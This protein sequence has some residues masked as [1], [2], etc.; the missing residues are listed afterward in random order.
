MNS[1]DN[2]TVEILLATYNG[3]KFLRNQLD[4]ILD[5]TYT[6]W[7]LRIRDD[8]S[9]D[10][11]PEIIKEYSEKYPEKII[12]CEDNKPS[13]C[14]KNNFFKLLGMAEEN[15]IMCCDQ[16][17]V[18]KPNKIALTLKKLLEVEKENSPEV[19]I[20]VFTDLTVVNEE[21]KETAHSFEMLSN[22]DCTRTKLNYLLVQNVVTG[23]TM[24]FNKALCNLAIQVDNLKNV[25]MH[26][27]WL[28]LTASAFG[29]IE[30]IPQQTIY[31]R[32][33]MS[34]SVGA[35]NVASPKYIINKVFVDNDIKQSL[36]SMNLQA[37]EFYSSFHDYL[38]PDDKHLIE[39]FISLPSKGKLKR[40]YNLCK[41]KYY[42]NGF[43][44]KVA[45]ILWA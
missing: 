12:V 27:G 13:G 32:Q 29:K 14:A 16:D 26:D 41:N 36:V 25:T 34:N 42:K 2:V 44:R 28:A 30:Y 45:Q 40:I 19:P 23:C 9:K 24:M 3:E 18:W 33:H 5:Q 37:K 4:S 38:S 20:L 22:L 43:Y 6:N 35:K 39:K 21:L 15:Y 11:T 7:I 1:K 31:Y 17:D 10:K 8:S